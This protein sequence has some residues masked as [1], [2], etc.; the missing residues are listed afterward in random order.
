MKI[1]VIETDTLLLLKEPT[2]RWSVFYFEAKDQPTQDDLAEVLQAFA[3]TIDDDDTP[4]CVVLNSLKQPN[5]RILAALVGI[6]A[7]KDGGERRVALAGARK[8]WLDMLD[9]L[10]VAS[11]FV[12][13]D[14]VE[15]L[16]EEEDQG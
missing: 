10:G 13:L 9:I 3:T 4:V 11:R 14:S 1:S 5:S 12:I 16:A 2:G 7:T 8:G 15:E 6:L